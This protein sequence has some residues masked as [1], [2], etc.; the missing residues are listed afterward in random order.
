MFFTKYLRRR[1]P[2]TKNVLGM[3]RNLKTLLLFLGITLF[4]IV[5]ICVSPLL[6]IAGSIVA[7]VLV[8][9]KKKKKKNNDNNKTDINK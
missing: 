6:I 3:E 9:N 7:I 4:L 8:A 2:R 5:L 1:L